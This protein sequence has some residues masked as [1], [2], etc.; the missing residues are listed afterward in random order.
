MSHIFFA[1]MGQT[2]PPPLCRYF[3]LYLEVRRLQNW[4]KTKRKWNQNGQIINWM[5]TFPDTGLHIELEVLLVIHQSVAHG[6]NVLH[7]QVNWKTAVV[8]MRHILFMCTHV[9]RD[10]VL[11]A[12]N[13][14]YRVLTQLLRK[15][16]ILNIR[17]APPLCLW[18][19]KKHNFIIL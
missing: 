10:S 1:F 4:D 7:H 5:K 9:N 16:P 2:R 6:Q 15:V 17:S 3:G 12:L 18:V 11:S 13:S 8:W 14:T 19:E